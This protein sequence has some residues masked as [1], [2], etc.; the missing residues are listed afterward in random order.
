MLPR[1]E[2]AA[3][4]CE[5][6]KTVWELQQKSKRELEESQLR[7]PGKLGMC[8][9][10][11]EPDSVGISKSNSRRVLHETRHES[12]SFSMQTASNEPQAN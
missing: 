2:R 8:P 11:A 7:F 5:A 1:C 6:N 4:I 12:E 9:S 10:L 3:H